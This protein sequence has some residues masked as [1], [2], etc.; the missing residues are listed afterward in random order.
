MPTLDV[1]EL[2]III[3]V[4]GM[5]PIPG[6]IKLAANGFQAL[7]QYFMALGQSR[8]SRYGTWAKHSQHCLWASS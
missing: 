8:S 6:P 1:S 5:L 7:S 2:N 4:L 3:A